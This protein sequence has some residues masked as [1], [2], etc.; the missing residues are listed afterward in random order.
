MEES[1]QYNCEE[2]ASPIDDDDLFCR[3]CGRPVGERGEV[4]P[5]GEGKKHRRWLYAAAA[6]G[7]ITILCG[8]TFAVLYLTVWGRVSGGADSPEAL[9][10]KYMESLQEEDVESYMECFEFEHF[11]T[12]WGEGITEDFTRY[13]I[14]AFMAM[15]DISFEGIEMKEISRE[16]DQACIRANEGEIYSKGFF[17]PIHYDVA[18][19]PMTFEMYRKDGKWFL[20]EDPMKGIVAPG[21]NP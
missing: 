5:P 7:G 3:G 11:E 13:M 4:V 14:K 15:G 17:M 20:A 10:D 21:P 8:I 1:E 9:V 2:C 18:D 19:Y 12:L 16:D 6:A